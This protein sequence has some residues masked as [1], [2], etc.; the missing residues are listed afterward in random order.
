MIGS[1]VSGLSAAW[2][3]SQRHVVTLFEAENRLGGHANT[4]E[5]RD[6]RGNPVPIDTGFIVYNSAAYPNLVAL[7]DH[8]KI[9]TTGTDMGFGVSLDDGAYEYAGGSMAQLIGNLSNLARSGHWRM[10]AD[11]A[12]FFRSAAGDA[13]TADD[14]LTLSGYLRHKNYSAEFIDRHLLPMSAAIWSSEPGQMMDYPV[15]SFLRFFDNHG[16]LKFTNRPQWR[17]VTGGSREYVR[18]LV[19]ASK[20][21]V[22]LGHPVKRVA[23]LAKGVTVDGEE[24]D[25]V[26]IATHADQA[27]AMLDVPSIEETQCLSKLPYAINRAVLHRDRS[28]MPKRRRLWSSWNY[29]GTLSGSGS[30]VTYWMNKLQPLATEDDYFVTLNPRIEPAPDTVAGAFSYAHPVFSPA[31]MEAQRKLW[32]LQGRQRTWFCGAYFG[33]GFHEDGLQAGL[34]VAEELGGLTRPWRVANPSGRI[35]L[36]VDSERTRLQAAE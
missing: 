23:R 25:H 32:R 31:A 14:S 35:Q 2:L 27:L 29:A 4:V 17:T 5:C 15:R 20:L 8:L 34:A 24:F 13:A 16:L 3:L 26:V 6:T 36:T 28:L 30:A 10:L 18:R 19:A 22:K 7:F 12:R 9:A 21:H 1:G 33:S 11:M